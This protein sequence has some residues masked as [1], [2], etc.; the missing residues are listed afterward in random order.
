VEQSRAE[1]EK[2]VNNR[3]FKAAMLQVE[4]M[5]TLSTGGAIRE[6]VSLDEE[7]VIAQKYFPKRDERDTVPPEEDYPAMELTLKVTPDQVRYQ[8]DNLDT[9]SSAGTTGMTNTLLKKMSQDPQRNADIPPAAIHVALAGHANKI[10]SGTICQGGRRLIV[11][12]RMHLVPKLEVGERPIVIECAIQRLFG[13][14]AKKAVCPEVG[15]TIAH[16]QLGTD[17]PMAGEIITRMLNNALDH[18][19]SVMQLDNSNAYGNVRIQPMFSAIMRSTPSLVQFEMWKYG[20][21]VEIRNSVGKIIA[22]RQTG[23]G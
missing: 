13:T 15:P 20:Q 17:V 19:D 1:C 5:Q 3:R 6:R 9:D 12:T 2:Q 23:F 10:L 21:D 7:E 18:G 11:G 14:V 4:I 22:V 8:M 16:L